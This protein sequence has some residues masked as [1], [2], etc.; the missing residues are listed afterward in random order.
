MTEA[1]TSIQFER[2]GVEAAAK[3]NSSFVDNFPAPFAFFFICVDIM[4]MVAEIWCGGEV[5]ACNN[6]EADDVLI[7]MVMVVVIVKLMMLMSKVMIVVMV[8]CGLP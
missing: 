7:S 1:R 6:F 2:S 8:K 4:V 3:K 5:D